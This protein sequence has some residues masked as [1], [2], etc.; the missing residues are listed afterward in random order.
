MKLQTACGYWDVT[1]EGLDAHK[2]WYQQYV[3]ATGRTG[4]FNQLP[5][6]MALV[7]LAAWFGWH[8]GQ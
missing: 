5:K 4:T 6:Y 3:V 7:I 2:V 8:A 1:I